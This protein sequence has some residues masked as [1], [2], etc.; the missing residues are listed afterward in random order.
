MGLTVLRSMRDNI[1]YDNIATIRRLPSL[2]RYLRGSE[3]TVKV[4]HLVKERV[5]RSYARHYGLDTFVETGTYRGAMISAVRRDFRTICSIELDAALYN[6]AQCRFKRFRHIS[7]VY[8]DSDKVLPDVV[9][10]LDRP[11]LFWLDAHYSGGVTARGPVDTPIQ[12]EIATLLAHRQSHVVLIDDAH[13]FIGRDGYPTLRELE[14]KV[15]TVRPGSQFNVTD[16]I[17]RMVLH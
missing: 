2:W 17:I 16:N 14:N 13:E 3:S 7:I 9:A 6:E 12:S 10:T 15:E 5:V 11:A 1:V 4:P 8:G